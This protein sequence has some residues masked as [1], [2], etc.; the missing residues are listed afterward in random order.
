M[1]C[2]AGDALG[3]FNFATKIQSMMKVTKF[4]V[5][6][7]L[8][9]STTDKRGK[10]PIMGRIT[11]NNSMVQFSCKLSCTP[12]SW[13]PRSGRLNG[14]SREAVEVNA[15]IDKLLLKINS[16]Y[17]NLFKRNVDFTAQNIKE[18]MQ[19]SVEGQVT[20]LKMTDR[21][22]KDMGERV[23]ID[24]SAATLKGFLLVRDNLAK[25][26]R[27]RYRVGDIAFGQMNN[28][29]IHD[30]LEFLLGECGYARKTT[31]IY[32]SRLK[33]VCRTAYKEGYADKCHFSN[34]PMPKIPV[35][36]P[37]AI[38][39]ENLRRITDL[40]IPARNESALISRDLLL[41]ACYT[42][43]AYA[44]T[45][46]VTE[47][48]LVWDEDGHPWLKYHRKKTNSPAMVRLLPEAMALIEKYRDDKRKTLMPVQKYST[49]LRNLRTISR[50]AGS[51]Q[52]V[53]HHMA[54]H[55]FTSIATL[56]EDVPIEVISKM[57]GHKDVRVTQIYARVTQ[58]KLFEDARKFA[59]AT[60]DMTLVL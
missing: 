50:D 22:C 51:T 2:I 40:D 56:A 29:F 35:S 58:K 6:L 41:F 46:S 59:E 19:G 53:S 47:D 30:Y 27:T 42:G 52:T 33:Q 16:A 31:W 3:L 24:R 11:L 55:Y 9:K 38:T 44:D 45:I 39:P 8:K 5:L 60:K 28:Q 25:F 57:L 54:R 48:N 43:T 7:Y 37:K 1:F 26:L 12:N 23:G 15:K 49:L 34:F 21:L 4:K 36:T 32:I 14:K 18:L 20:L 17:D 13:N 10:A